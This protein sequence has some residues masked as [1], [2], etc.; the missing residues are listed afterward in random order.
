MKKYKMVMAN[1]NEEI[2]SLWIP[3]GFPITIELFDNWIRDIT[4]NNLKALYKK[5]NILCFAPVSENSEK[6]LVIPGQCDNGDIVYH[7]YKVTK[8]PRIQEL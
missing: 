5:N 2:A 6:Y 8:Q 1:L 3:F 4:Q 7:V